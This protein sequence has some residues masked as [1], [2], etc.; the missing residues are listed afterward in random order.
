MYRRGRPVDQ[1]FEPS[2][3]LYRRYKREHW[4]DNHFSNTGLRFPDES[5]PSV[6]R[7]KY[8]EPEDVLFSPSGEFNRWGVLKFRVADIPGPI[9]DGAGCLYLFSAR[10]VPEDDNYAHSELWAATAGEGAKPAR[11]SSRVK[12]EFRVRLSQRIT[13]CIEALL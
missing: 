9:E 10:H 11:P 8:S 5:G 2:E 12:K 3:Q 6:N 7:G 1:E 4:V 13:V